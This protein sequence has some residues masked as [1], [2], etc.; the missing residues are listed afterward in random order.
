MSAA[1]RS[2]GGGRA[3]AAGYRVRPAEEADLAAL[4]EI[5]RG[6][7]GRFAQGHAALLAGVRAD[8]TS[9]EDFRHAWRAGLL[10]VAVD[11]AGRP[12]GFALARELAGSLHLDELDVAPEHGRRGVGAALVDAVC[13]LARERGHER[14]TLTTFASVP[15]NAPW[16]E[17]QGFRVVDPS[18]QPEEIRR[19]VA[20][21][22]RDGLDPAQ[23]VVMR[24]RLGG[25]RRAL[26]WVALLWLLGV[27]SVSAA[28]STPA[29]V[30]NL[31]WAARLPGRDKTAHFVLMGG[32]AFFAVLGFAGTR[33]GGRRVSG[34]AV[35]GG[36]VALV[37]LEE[38]VQRWI[39]L[40]A[41]SLEDFAW[42][43]AGVACLG[44]A[45]AGWQRWTRRSRG[46]TS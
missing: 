18:D 24:R 35:L 34:P 9:P 22:A 6:A 3:R 13:D 8:A 33:L 38:I 42:S 14:V 29:G 43:L 32:L 5:E 11:A 2:R 36:V 10:R 20:A 27:A 21:E 40:R 30:A 25:P 12:V 46:P 45:A 44:G 19:V 17:A 37:T 26:R 41:F 23:R 1:P 31:A 15:W 7:T 4:P 16:Y 39:P 28:A